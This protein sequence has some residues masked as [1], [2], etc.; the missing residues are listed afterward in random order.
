MTALQNRKIAKG[1]H[2]LLKMGSLAQRL[3]N[4]LKTNQGQTI[5]QLATAEKEIPQSVNG[6]LQRMKTAG[7][8]TVQPINK[9]NRKVS[10]YF[11]VTENEGGHARDEL[12]IDCMIYVNEYGEYS[13][14]ARIIDQSPLAHEGN[15]RAWH[16][17]TFTMTVPKPDEPARTRTILDDG[18]TIIHDNKDLVIEGE[19]IDIKMK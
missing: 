9:G 6:M 11:A 13:V 19:I 18:I 17:H 15:P 2:P 7:L 10:G 16:Q 5:Q 14:K 1:R 12:A 4:R 3:F 8:V